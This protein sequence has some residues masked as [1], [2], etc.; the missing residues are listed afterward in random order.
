VNNGVYVRFENSPTGYVSSDDNYIVI[1]NISKEY[2]LK[3]SSVEV[4]GADLVVHTLG[5]GAIEPGEEMRLR[6]TGNLPE[7]SNALLQVNV[8]YELVGNTT[9]PIGKKLV[10]FKM[11]NGE[12]P[13]YDENAPYVDADYTTNYEK[14]MGDTDDILVNFGL[15]YFVSYLYQMLMS[16]LDQIGVGMFLK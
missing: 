1:K 2:P 7:V 11:M 9:A 16:F 6:V 15:S 12:S 13:V 5:A 10:N 4:M 3:I 8:N 14:F